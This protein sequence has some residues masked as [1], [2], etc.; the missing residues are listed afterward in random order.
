MA[1]TARLT[2]IEQLPKEERE[3]VEDLLRERPRPSGAEVSAMYE[4]RFKK[5]LAASTIYSH[6]ARRMEKQR[7]AIEE[8][9]ADYAAAAE[10]IGEQGLDTAAQAQLWEVVQEMKPAQL[11]LLRS[12]ETKRKELALK[13]QEGIR[14]Q[15]ELELK[16]R[17]FET[18]EKQVKEVV[19]EAAKRKLTPAEFQMRLD[20]VY[21]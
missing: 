5:E 17:Q 19:G 16:I 6:L 21:C 9:K 13:E 15:G 1:E 14:K 4:D 20:E 11:I 2:K 8:R 3:F 7:Q 12:V 18:R 10:V